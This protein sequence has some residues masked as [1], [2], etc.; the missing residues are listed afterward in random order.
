MR[1]NLSTIYLHLHFSFHLFVQYNYL[2]TITFSHLSNNNVIFYKLQ[3]N[4]CYQFVDQSSYI[5]DINY[6]CF[7]QVLTDHTQYSISSC[8]WITYFWDFF[9]QISFLGNG[10]GG[11][12][13]SFEN[14]HLTQASSLPKGTVRREQATLLWSWLPALFSSESISFF[15]WKSF[16]FVAAAIFRSASSQSRLYFSFFPHP[17]PL[18]SISCVVQCASHSRIPSSRKLKFPL[19]SSFEKFFLMQSR[20][21]SMHIFAILASSIPFFML[22]KYSRTIPR[23]P[24]KYICDLICESLPLKMCNVTFCHFTSNKRNMCTHIRMY[25]PIWSLLFVVL[26]FLK[27]RPLVS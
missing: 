7:I 9:Y 6:H 3:I 4:I 1:S 12:Y 10:A 27:Y 13:D 8:N 15:H 2:T 20:E 23:H 19:V 25:E 21:N 18:L 14:C 26:E 5:W 24:L 17:L 22:R 16:P 11:I